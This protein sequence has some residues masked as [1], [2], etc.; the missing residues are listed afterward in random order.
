MVWGQ[1]GPTCSDATKDDFLFASCLQDTTP[2]LNLSM[3]RE[4]LHEPLTVNV[5]LWF[6]VS[7][8]FKPYIKEEVLISKLA[9]RLKREM[10]MI[11]LWHS[12]SIL[13][14]AF[15]ACQS[16]TFNVTFQGFLHATRSSIPRQQLEATPDVRYFFVPEGRRVELSQHCLS[17]VVNFSV[18]QITPSVRK[19]R[20]LGLVGTSIGCVVGPLV[21][22]RLRSYWNAGGR[23]ELTSSCGF[24]EAVVPRLKDYYCWLVQKSGIHQLR[25]VVEVP[26]IYGVSYIPGGL[27]FQ[28]TVY[29]S[30]PNGR[31]QVF[32]LVVMA[33]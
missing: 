12:L 22:H 10:I 14:S 9:P 18:L 30:G 8:R 15:S 13:F 5:V 27:G 7:Q 1:R 25:L 3:R 20:S 19:W 26:F 33:R 16:L 23:Y 32:M 2:A 11:I 29:H 21:F 31:N 28:P 17:M 4:K 6:K 24:Q